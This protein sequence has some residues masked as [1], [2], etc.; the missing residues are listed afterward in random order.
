M[1]DDVAMEDVSYQLQPH[2]KFIIPDDLDL[3][4]LGSL[5]QLGIK[6]FLYQRGQIAVPFESLRIAEDNEDMN[7]GVQD[8]LKIPEDLTDPKQRLRL[9]VSAYTKVILFVC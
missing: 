2:C 8:V 9:L 1:S 4:Q 3:P 7:Q 5:I 6:F